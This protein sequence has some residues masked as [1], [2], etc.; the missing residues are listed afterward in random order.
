[1]LSL[2]KLAAADGG[3]YYLES[4]ASGLDEY[5]RGHGEAPGVWVGPGSAS[6]GLE[7]EVTAGQLD[8]L[9]AGMHPT[10]AV[11]TA[12]TV[13]GH[14]GPVSA[15]ERLVARRSDGVPGFDCTFS[16]PKG[17]SLL[18]AFGDRATSLQVVGAHEAAVAAALAHLDVHAAHA[19]RG[20][21]GTEQIDS[22]GLVC[23]TFRHRSSRNGDPQL[24]THVLVANAVRGTDGRWSALDARGLHRERLAAGALYQAVLRHELT[25]RLGVEWGPVSAKGQADLAEIDPGLVALFSSRRMEIRAELAA[26]GYSSAHAAEAATLATRKPKDHS[27]TAASLDQR[28][29]TQA[30][31]AG[32][33][34]RAVALLLDATT[35]P[36]APDKAGRKVIVD[37]LAGA[38]GLTREASTFTRAHVAA[39]VAAQLPGGA[40]R[41][42][43]DAL[44]SA[45]LS[46]PRVVDLDRRPDLGLP[47]AIRRRDGRVVTDP[48]HAVRYTT[49]DL[50]AAERRLLDLSATPSRGIATV[51]P[52]GIELAIAAG[53]P[54]FDDQTHMVHR[55]CASGTPLDVVTGAAGCGKTTGLAAAHRAWAAS[56]TRVIGACLAR[57]A[58]QRLGDETGMWTTSL[59]DLLGRLDRADPHDRLP[60]GT[61]VVIDEAGQIGTRDLD[62]LADHIG[63]A[64]GKLVLVG[65]ARQVGA[66]DAGGVL[67]E[68]VAASGSDAVRLLHNRRQHLA[69]E[70]VATNDLRRGRTDSAVAAYTDHGRIHP[71]DGADDLVAKAVAG[72]WSSVDAGHDALLV[73][74]TLA[75]VGA[76]NQL[77]RRGAADRR[78][79]SGPE[80]EIGGRPWSAGDRITTRTNNRNLGV[81]NGQRWEIT[82]VNSDGPELRIRPLVGDGPARTLPSWYL[83]QDGV[84]EHAYATTVF[85]AQGATTDHCHILAS[86]HLAAELGY[87][88]ATRGRTENHFYA[89][90]TDIPDLAGCLARSGNDTAASTHTADEW[91]LQDLSAQLGALERWHQTALGPDPGPDLV[92]AQRQLRYLHRRRSH[93]AD[94]STSP[95]SPW[96]SNGPSPLSISSVYAR[97][98]EK[99]L[100][101]PS[102]R[103]GRWGANASMRR[104]SIGAN[105]S[106][107]GSATIPRRT[108]SSMFSAP[109]PSITSCGTRGTRPPEP[110]RSTGTDG[111]SL[112][113]T[114]GPSARLP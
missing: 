49:V 77:A 88:A 87:V 30:A 33:D 11:R 60:A 99:R 5:Y 52:D 55:L 22:G 14:T 39:A 64:A 56:G 68:L 47:E 43:V 80:I 57:E 114:P 70:R 72:Y 61:V 65:D 18:W 91:T 98:N 89:L 17:V 100:L 1:M 86:E 29:R 101:R 83:A 37:H 4:V 38:T 20:R 31:E 10:T 110:S 6:L 44:V 92:D 67:P 58:A 3:R 9:L 75:Q 53:P 96:P 94:P 26:H 74:V 102:R 34:P 54:L 76:A 104:L 21:N 63:K 82:A 35:T 7:G 108:T 42:G 40:T 103:P 111:G 97:P 15:G 12:A 8:A 25:D 107:S 2:H 36:P 16:A 105:G 46:D 71:A 78:L 45:V 85:R 93:L 23:A 50:L 62:R 27:Q 59:A 66:I 106:P 13:D 32:H 24:H 113:T 90:A 69:W 112:P 48:H 41:A 95:A 81:T 109:D 51:P 73:G 79:L 19:R 28:W 84:I